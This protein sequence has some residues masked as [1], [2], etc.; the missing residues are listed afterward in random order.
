[1][2]TDLGGKMVIN[3]RNYKNH[4]PIEYDPQES[5]TLDHFA[6]YKWFRSMLDHYGFKEPFRLGD[7]LE[8]HSARQNLEHQAEKSVKITSHDYDAWGFPKDDDFAPEQIEEWGFVPEELLLR[9]KSGLLRG[10]ELKS[11]EEFYNRLKNVKNIR[12]PGKIKPINVKI[13]VTEATPTRIPSSVMDV[14][15]LRLKYPE[16]YQ[17][18]TPINIRKYETSLEDPTRFTIID[19]GKYAYVLWRVLKDGVDI[20]LGKPQKVTEGIWVGYFIWDKPPEPIH[21][22]NTAFD[23]T[24]NDL[25]IDIPVIQKEKKSRIKE[26]QRNGIEERRFR[27]KEI[28]RR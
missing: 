25:A 10:E 9:W 22:L 16:K 17:K 8:I 6:S 21:I 7:K 23:E 3:N 19:D 26:L 11:E 2:K 24:W 5:I 20:E 15:N 14:Y 1:M 28:K 18:G 27:G 4:I 12:N 13:L